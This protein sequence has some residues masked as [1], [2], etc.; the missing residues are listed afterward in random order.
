[1]QGSGMVP[2]GQGVGPTLQRINITLP[3]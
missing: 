1:M 3:K 2:T